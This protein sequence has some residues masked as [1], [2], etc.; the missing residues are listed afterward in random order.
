MLELFINLHFVILMV[1]VATVTYII[2][3]TVSLIWTWGDLGIVC[4]II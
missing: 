2:V 3:S 4:C 1:H